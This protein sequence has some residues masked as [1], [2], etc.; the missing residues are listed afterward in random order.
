MA[1]PSFTPPAPLPEENEVVLDYVLG[2]DAVIEPFVI[3]GLV[4]DP[5]VVEW[6]GGR[7]RQDCRN[8]TRY[9][10]HLNDTGGFTIAKV[11]KAPPC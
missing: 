9:W 5:G 10:P 4:G 11:R 2:A 6:A 8:L 7:L 3:P 1:E